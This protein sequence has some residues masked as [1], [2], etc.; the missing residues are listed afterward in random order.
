MV[1]WMREDD[2]QNLW[3]VI[4]CDKS[5]IF[6][7]ICNKISN[8]FCESQS[9]IKIWY[10]SNTISWPSQIT[11]HKF[12]TVSHKHKWIL[13]MLHWSDPKINFVFMHVNI[14]L[15]L[16]ALTLNLCLCPVPKLILWAFTNVVHDSL[17]CGE[18]VG[19]VAGG[20]GKVCSLTPPSFQNYHHIPITTSSIPPSLR[21]NSC[22][23]SPFLALPIFL[24]RREGE[25]LSIPA[26]GRFF[27]VP[28]L[29]KRDVDTI[30]RFHNAPWSPWSYC[31]GKN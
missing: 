31:H 30:K 25:D 6:F 10:C 12:M 3:F 14:N 20:S 22:I 7:V 29:L 4:V 9:Q 15:C 2:Q 23:A 5:S 27:L 21:C 11:N 17:L 8:I 28:S 19:R 18:R 26:I 13:G 1:C 24:Q 16:R